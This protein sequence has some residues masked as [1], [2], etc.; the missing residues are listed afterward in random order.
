[1]TT[2]KEVLKTFKEL[3]KK[4]LK[5]KRFD[6]PAKRE[7]WNNW[8]D[9]LCKDGTITSWQYDNWTQPF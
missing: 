9:A 3:H 7:A 8:T 5:E 6:Y 2:K 1:M 4:W